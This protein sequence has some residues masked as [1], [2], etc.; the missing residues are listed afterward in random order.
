MISFII[1]SICFIFIV[2]NAYKIGYDRGDID[3]T[4]TI[5]EA[6]KNQIA[7]QNNP[8]QLKLFDD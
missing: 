6:L 8:D 2:F 7:N 5:L 3:A 4:K 1:V